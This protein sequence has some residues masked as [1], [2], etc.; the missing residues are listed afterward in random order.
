MADFCSPAPPSTPLRP[1]ARK[2]PGNMPPTLNVASLI[3]R[4]SDSTPGASF[5]MDAANVVQLKHGQQH[6]GAYPTSE[7]W[8]PLLATMPQM[9][10]VPLR[11]G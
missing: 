6:E 1:R 2:Q 8:L 7:A 9:S 10:D 11:V 4:L 5:F 3:D